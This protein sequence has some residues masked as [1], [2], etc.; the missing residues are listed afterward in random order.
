MNKLTKNSF[1][2]RALSIDKSSSAVS[3][4]K[5]MKKLPDKQLTASHEVFKDLWK[6]ATQIFSKSLINDED[7][8]FVKNIL[9][10][11]VN[12]L[13]DELNNP[14][15][16]LSL[17]PLASFNYTNQNETSDYGPIWNYLFR[18]NFFEVVF[19]WSLSYPEYLFDLKLEQ[20][21]YYE[22]LV[23][24]MQTNEQTH[25][26]LNVQIHRPMFSLLNHCSTHNSEKIEKVMISILNQLCVCICKN[27]ELLQIFFYQAKMLTKDNDNSLFYI[28]GTIN[29]PNSVSNPYKFTTHFS[30]NKQY[31]QPTSSA[32]FFIFSLL[33][34]YI[35]KEGALGNYFLFIFS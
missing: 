6:Q 2:S 24:Q 33:I 30:T 27:S 4:D 22:D 10:Q 17:K 21:R 18:I 1:F 11:M 20:L 26:L 12:L 31:M 15:N 32:K 9:S 25:L 7:V 29:Y 16:Y 19:L 5:N 34:P 35:H 28:N 13:L 3:V 14:N 8:Q 23:Y